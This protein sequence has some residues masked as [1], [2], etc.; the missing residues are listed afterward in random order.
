MIWI[1]RRTRARRIVIDNDATAGLEGG[2]HMTDTMTTR[3]AES[4][5]RVG[6][7]LSQTT[8]VLSRHFP[9][10]FAIAAVANLPTLL[11]FKD[12]QSPTGDLGQAGFLLILGVVLSLVLSVVS[13]AVILYGAFQDMRG[14]PVNLGES[15]MVGLNRFF[16]I[17]GLA[18]VMSVLVAL[19]AIVFI[20]P[21]LILLTMWFV[22]T[23]ACVVER[24]GPWASLRRSSAL[25]KGH[26]WKI[27]GLMLVLIVVSALISPLVELV[28]TGIG[29]KSLS[30]V[31]ELIWNG[32]WG[33]F[34]AIAAVVAYHD[35]RVAKEGVDTEQI[36]AVFD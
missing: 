27:F 31:G 17:V 23:P 19:A 14:R 2:R 11:L 3:F 34:Y 5:F 25:T 32:V 20:I 9:T 16:P 24:R 21:G 35:L 1:M 33:A 12:A 29:G 15:L 7:V 30:F 4:D 18:I 36:A 26:R 10:F 22:G 28:L 8:T 13:Q 6:R